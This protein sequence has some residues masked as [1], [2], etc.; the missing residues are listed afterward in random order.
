ME[1]RK[2]QFVKHGSTLFGIGVV[3]SVL[4]ILIGLI[5]WISSESDYGSSNTDGVA[6][7][8]FLRAIAK[9]RDP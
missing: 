9:H 3:L 4:A 6:A 8:F 2:K 1:K 7:L 5:A